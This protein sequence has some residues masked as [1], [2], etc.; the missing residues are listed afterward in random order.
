M[1]LSQPSQPNLKNVKIMRAKA[2]RIIKRA[3]RDSWRT[4]ISR[5]NSN[6]PVKRVWD[7]VKRICGKSQPSA[8][9]HLMIDNN[10][11]EHPQDIA[12]TLT[13]TISINSSNKHCTKSLQKV[14]TFQEKRPL[15]FLSDN[16]EAYNQL[17]SMTELQD[18]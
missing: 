6:T 4:Y 17:F 13:S 11:M 8:I 5:L 2:R 16:T 3:K 1:F 10:R 14:K 7:M 15:K 12:Y 9:H 18:A